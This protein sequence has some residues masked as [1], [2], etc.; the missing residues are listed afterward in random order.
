VREVNH[1]LPSGDE[2]NN[3]WNCTSA[4]SVCFRGVDRIKF[5]F[6]LF[7]FVINFSFSSPCAP[8]GFEPLANNAGCSYTAICL[9]AVVD[10][11]GMDGNPNGSHPFAFITKQTALV[12]SNTTQVYFNPIVTHKFVLRVSAYQDIQR[13]MDLYL[14]GFCV[15]MLGDSLS[16]G[17]N[18]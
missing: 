1:S 14:Y 9:S 6:A 11:S 10:S 17:R 7:H 13:K 16:T 8:C 12:Q 18:T 4:H 3:Q 2:V 15:D 5:T